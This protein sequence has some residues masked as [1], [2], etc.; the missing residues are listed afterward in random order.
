MHKFIAPLLIASSFALTACPAD[1][2]DAKINLL[3]E[4]LAANGMVISLSGDIASGSVSFDAP[5]SD[6]P[7]NETLDLYLENSVTINVVSDESG[8]NT[9][10]G[11]MGV[12]WVAGTPAAAGEYNWSLNADRTTATLQ[13]FNLSP[14]DLTLKPGVAYTAE[15]AV[16]S[17]PYVNDVPATFIGVTVN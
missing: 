10:F 13:F 16:G 5:V 15:V 9:S 4:D 14:N 7:T 8:S 12:N 2:V 1:D 11:Q 17:N 6:T 3:V